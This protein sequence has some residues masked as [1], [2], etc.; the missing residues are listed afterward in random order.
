MVTMIFISLDLKRRG[1]YTILQYLYIWLMIVFLFVEMNVF[2]FMISLALFSTGY[3]LTK[4]KLFPIHSWKRLSLSD[5]R[6]DAFF[7]LFMSNFTNVSISLRPARGRKLLILFLTVGKDEALPYLLAR[8][9]VRGTESGRLFMRVLLLTA[10]LILFVN[11]LIALV[12][13]SVVL[14]ALNTR[15][16]TQGFP[17]YGQ[18]IPPHYPVEQDQY[19]AA[20]H[21]L[22][23]R[24]LLLQTAFFSCLLLIKW[25]SMNSL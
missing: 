7:T 16:F 10:A 17:P 2:I 13:I 23:K 18:L 12:L 5:Q 25:I 21:A 11:N 8:S 20:I 9:L 1:L 6:S 14:V 24:A 3:W 15:Q 4:N 19:S 22:Q